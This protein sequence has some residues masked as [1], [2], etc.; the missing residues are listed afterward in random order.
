MHF[1]GEFHLRKKKVVLAGRSLLSIPSDEPPFP[2]IPS[3]FLSVSKTSY[4]ST[5]FFLM[6]FYIKD[7]QS[8]H[9]Y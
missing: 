8:V 1:Q 3:I 2:M 9:V 5:G 4:F 7:Y 6:P